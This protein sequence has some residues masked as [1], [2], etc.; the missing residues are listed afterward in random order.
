MK[1][2]LGGRSYVRQ[3]WGTTWVRRRTMRSLRVATG[4]PGKGL[5]PASIRSMRRVRS[6]PAMTRK[7]PTSLVNTA[8]STMTPSMETAG[9]L[10]TTTTRTVRTE[11]ARRT[12]KARRQGRAGVEA[13]CK[14]E[15]FRAPRLPQRFRRLPA[16]PSCP[17]GQAPGRA[18]RRGVR[19]PEYS[20]RSVRMRA[21]CSRLDQQLTCRCRCNVSLNIMCRR[22]G[23]G[24][25]KDLLTRNRFWPSGAL[26]RSLKPKACVSMGAE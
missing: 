5:P 3:R 15:M 12:Q 9:W 13:K 20:F 7:R 21:S 17:K 24:S 14:A 23:H 1:N 19:G 8:C 2:T 4:M 11:V 25:T 18:T 10:P 26:A 6:S 16:R 22:R